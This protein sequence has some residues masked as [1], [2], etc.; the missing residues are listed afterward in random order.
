MAGHRPARGGA[1]ETMGDFFQRRTREVARFGREAEAAAHKA[2]GDALRSGTELV[3]RTPGEVT[4]F[5]ATLLD[6][7]RLTAEPPQRSG[8]RSRPLGS[9]PASG[10]KV[11]LNRN[12]LVRA[13]A[14]AVGQKVGNAAGVAR[15]G[16]HAV[17]GLAE[18]AVFVQRLTNPFVASMSPLDEPAAQQLVGAASRGIDYV[19]RGLADPEVVVD[20]V[21]D[22]AHQ[23][24]IDLD[25]TATP[26][27]PTVSE[28]I[29]RRLEIGMNQGELAFDVG[30]FAVGGPLAKSMRGLGAVSRAST[31]EKYLAQGFTSAQAA[32]L[33][34]PYPKR[35]MGHHFA[36]RRMGLPQSY[37]ESV[38]N[39]LKPE[40]ITRG[41]MYKLHYIVD[42]DFHGT[43]FPA[44]V[45]GGRWSGA[46]LGLKKHNLAGR[47][48]HGSP[49][50]L[51]AR[52]GGL[53]A[54]AGAVIHTAED[55]EG[56]W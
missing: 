50:P 15:G 36:P 39:L 47:L 23:A 16:V 12:P 14:G 54:S 44:R 48:W 17:Q 31:A 49:A 40:G 22:M 32:H 9:R 3:L 24:R 52:V 30:S 34:K 41:D 13:V 55:E 21:R 8:P 33:A 1:I 35:G 28:E 42:P 10:A 43:G 11:E 25:P 20:D 29:R 19:R 27:A 18:G 53:G 46:D 5:G 7:R 56:S 6:G 26:V 38:F 51:K 45:G 37:S 4:R 2:Y